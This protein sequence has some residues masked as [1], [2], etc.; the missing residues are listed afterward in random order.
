[1][2]NPWKTLEPSDIETY[3]SLVKHGLVRLRLRTVSKETIV[4]RVKSIE[5]GNQ[6]DL[7]I[8]ADLTM[9]N[10]WNKPIGTNHKDY[11][12]KFSTPVVLSRNDKGKTRR[13]FIKAGNEHLALL[14]RMIAS[15]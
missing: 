11:T 9:F 6:N 3:L 15:T 5:I 8:N 2:Y 10:R 1:M 4:G 7:V 14:G 13:L 12:L